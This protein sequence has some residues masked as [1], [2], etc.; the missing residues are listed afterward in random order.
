MTEL[1]EGRP[2]AALLTLSPLEPYIAAC[3]RHIDGIH[4]R[5]VCAIAR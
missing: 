1:A 3:A 4:L 2:E 5:A